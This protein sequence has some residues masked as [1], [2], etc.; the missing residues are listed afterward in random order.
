[1]VRDRGRQMGRPRPC[2]V[3]EKMERKIKLVR[4]KAMKMQMVS[5]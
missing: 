3:G 5:L 2:G 4:Y 1:M